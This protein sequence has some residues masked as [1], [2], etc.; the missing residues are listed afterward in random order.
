MPA[1][2]QR[3]LGGDRTVAE[4]GRQAGQP[5]PLRPGLRLAGPAGSPNVAP[6]GVRARSGVSANTQAT[7]LAEPLVMA[8]AAS[9]TAAPAEAP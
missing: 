2:G 6:A 3:V 4:S 9:S 8:S 1:G 5:V 7:A